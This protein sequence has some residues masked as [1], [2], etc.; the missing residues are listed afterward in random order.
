MAKESNRALAL[1]LA[2]G[3]LAGGAKAAEGFHWGNVAIGGGGFVSAIV[4]SPLEKG[5][6]YARTDVGGAYRW[7][8]AQHKWI[9]LTDWVGP[10]QVGLLGV[11]AIA[12]DPKVPGKVYMTC[13]TIYFDQ[14][15]DG[16]GK[17]AFLR[18][19]DYGKTW[20]QVA[21]WN[22]DVKWFWVHGNGMGRGNGERLAIDPNDPDVMF[23]GSRRNGLWKSVDN[24]TTWSH[25]D[26]FTTAAQFDTT[27]NGCGFSFVQYAP[28]SSTQLYAGFLR[29]ADNVFQS[30]DAGKTWSLVPDR[31]KPA[32]KGGY[33]PRLMPQRLA[34]A[35]DSGY[36][37][38]DSPERS[39]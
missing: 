17:S 20:E 30:T 13:G 21:I 33:A 24:G 22:D 1:A 7:D 26:A 2:L 39:A 18:S 6:F 34:I 15:K 31:P 35:P 3:C 23:Y 8:D 28:G 16:F 37:Y 25:V 12:V 14:A 32:T 9:P 36:A 4:A 5:L 19:K 11:E 10:D 38:G 29:S 27:W